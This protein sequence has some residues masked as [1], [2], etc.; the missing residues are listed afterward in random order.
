MSYPKNA[1]S[2]PPIFATVVKAADGTPITVGVAAKYS[3]GAHQ[4]AGGGTLHGEDNGQWSYI[5]TQAETNVSG[6]G[7]QFYHADAV[8]T[9]PTVSVVTDT[10]AATLGTP[11][12]ASVSAD[13]LQV[14]NYV[15]DIGAA[16][17]GLTALGD[18]RIANLD[19][20]VST[21]GTPATNADAVWDEVLHTFHEVASSA[22]VLLQSAGAAADPLLNTV[23][24]AYAIGTAGY[25]LGIIGAGT[26]ATITTPVLGSVLT[27]TIGATFAATIGSLTLSGAYTLMD[28]SLKRSADDT[29]ANAILRIRVSNPA[30]AATDGALIVEGVAA[31]AGQRILAGLTVTAGAG[32]VAL[33]ATAALTAALSTHAALVW[34]LKQWT[35][36]AQTVVATGTALVQHTPTWAVT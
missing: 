27:V 28:F 13:V 32:T 1:A 8:G 16:G 21:R 31:T 5:P 36:A 7:I 4:G 14:K 33:A 2:P 15:D 6:F 12:G 22:S 18:T 23:P 29:D 35:A 10:L 26:T 3:I 25:A 34:D 11:A 20:A 17:A 24:G 19:A 9:G 30:A